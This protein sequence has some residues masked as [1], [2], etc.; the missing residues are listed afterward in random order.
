MVGPMYGQWTWCHTV[1]LASKISFQVCVL[2]YCLLPL[3]LSLV[4]ILILWLK[5][6]LFVHFSVIQSCLLGQVL[7]R[8]ILIHSPTTFLVVL[9]CLVTLAGKSFFLFSSLAW[10]GLALIGFFEYCLKCSGFCWSTFASM[11]FLGDC[12][13]PARWLFTSTCWHFYF[14]TLA[15]KGVPWQSIPCSF[16]TSSSGGW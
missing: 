1:F 2:G 13:A 4:I 11:Q 9:R 7:C 14:L 3:A 10:F 12:T 5:E 8:I 15:L 16:S 6:K